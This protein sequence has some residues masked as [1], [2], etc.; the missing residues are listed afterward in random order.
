MYS[1]RIESYKNIDLLEQITKML[2]TEY[3]IDMELKVFGE[4]PY[5]TKLKKILDSLGI[6]YEIE[7]FQ[8]FEKYI[9]LLSHASLYGLLSQKESYPQSINEANA[10]GVP[11]LIAKPWGINFHGR[12]RTLIID[13]NNNIRNITKMV[14]E[15]LDRGP[16]EQRSDVPTWDDVVNIYIEKLYVGPYHG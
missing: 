16:K 8:P 10:I 15:F 5:N 12:S 4:G 11:T 1:V 13:L 14:Y 9:E 2:N 7:G 3:G 6:R